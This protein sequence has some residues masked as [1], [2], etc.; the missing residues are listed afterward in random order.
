[1]YINISEQQR[2]VKILSVLLCHFSDC[3]LGWTYL[4]FGRIY[5]G[6]KLAKNKKK[7]RQLYGY[8]AE[9]FPS[10]LYNQRSNYYLPS[11]G[12]LVPCSWPKIT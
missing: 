11:I 3:M 10:Q 6:N 2:C 8:M 4:L 1:M 7:I 5:I 9:N 12:P